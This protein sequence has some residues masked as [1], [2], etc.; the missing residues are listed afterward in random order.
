MT[1]A[2]FQ[3]LGKISERIQML[4]SLDK[5]SAKT[6]LDSFKILLPIWSGPVALF[7]F[8]VFRIFKTSDDSTVLVGRLVLQKRGRCVH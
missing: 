6:R 3:A 7:I 5:G 8:E 1:C 4:N 2:R